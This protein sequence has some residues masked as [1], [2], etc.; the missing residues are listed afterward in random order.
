MGVLLVGKSDMGKTTC[1]MRVPKPWYAPADDDTLVVPDEEGRYVAHP[2]PTWSEFLHRPRSLK[3]WE[4]HR[5]VP[6]AGVFFLDKAAQDDIRPLQKSM[7]AYFL[8]KATLSVSRPMCYAKLEPSERLEIKR[9]YFENMAELSRSVPIFILSV[10]LH[11]K[12]WTLI[13]RAVA[14]SLPSL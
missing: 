2:F 5:H 12:F 4:V 7:A 11:G 14:S 9:V 13:E 1:S 3:K 6:L 8:T 10:S